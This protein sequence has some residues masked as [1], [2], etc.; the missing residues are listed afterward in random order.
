MLYILKDMTLFIKATGFISII[1]ACNWDRRRRFLHLHLF[2]L[3]LG[4]QQAVGGRSQRYA[5]APAS[6]YCLR[7]YSPGGICSGMLAI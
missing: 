5:S 4:L 6:W 2:C 7:I 1:H 3:Q